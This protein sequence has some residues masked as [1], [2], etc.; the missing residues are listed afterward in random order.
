[1]SN[2]VKSNVNPQIRLRDRDVLTVSTAA[3]VTVTSA[4][5]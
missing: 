5:S 3:A 2:Q 4:V 1:M